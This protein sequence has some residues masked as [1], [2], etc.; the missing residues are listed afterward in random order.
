MNFPDKIPIEQWKIWLNERMLAG[1]IHDRSL[2]P[3]EGLAQHAVIKTENYAAV[4]T[5]RGDDMILKKVE[6]CGENGWEAY[7][8]GIEKQHIADE[9]FATVLRGTQKAVARGMSKKP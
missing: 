6:I 1:E 3:K 5:A 2:L 8:E 4:Y 7:L 9:R